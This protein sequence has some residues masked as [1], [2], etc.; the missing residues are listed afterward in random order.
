M[1][2]P[3]QM[4]VN[5]PQGLAAHE[6]RAVL[7]LGSAHGLRKSLEAAAVTLLMNAHQQQRC[8]VRT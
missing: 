7:A 5:I 3:H 6:M 2:G 4:S 1:D 8:V